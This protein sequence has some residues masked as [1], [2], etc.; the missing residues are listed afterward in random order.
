MEFFSSRI[1][2]FTLYLTGYWFS[3]R[4]SPVKCFLQTFGIT[5]TALSLIQSLL[6]AVTS[7]SINGNAASAV[8]SCISCAMAI[9]KI[10]AVYSNQNELWVIKFELHRISIDMAVTKRPKFV[11]DFNNFRRFVN[12]IFLLTFVLSVFAYIIVPAIQIMLTLFT[13]AAFSKTL[14]NFYWFPFDINEYFIIVRIYDLLISNMYVITLLTVE[15]LLMITL[16]Q[17]AV[18]FKCLAEDIVELIDNHDETKPETTEEELVNKIDLHNKLLFLTKSITNIYEK[19]MLVHVM[20][21]AFSTCLILLKVFVVDTSEDVLTS[22]LVLFNMFVYFYYICFC[23]EKIMESVS[24]YFYFDI[25][26]IELK[27]NSLLRQLKSLVD[28]KKAII[29][30]SMFICKNI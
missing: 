29:I 14:L 11:R 6:F 1:L 4:S 9:V 20:G 24:I 8:F 23:G 27:K 12:S 5:S 18:L 10:L 13:G 30:V 28:L 17:V 15:G 2:N 21:F 22:C 7:K 25:I 19:A 16:G 26:I 3:T